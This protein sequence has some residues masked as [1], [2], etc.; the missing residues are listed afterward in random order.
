MSV[1]S[2]VRLIPYALLIIQ[3]KTIRDPIMI[4][5]FMRLIMVSSHLHGTT[6]KKR[7]VA[8]FSHHGSQSDAA[9]CWN[10]AVFPADISRENPSAVGAPLSDKLN[11]FVS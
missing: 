9:I 10:D 6:S 2:D 7:E 5:H 4:N 1:N 11:N 3:N 8:S